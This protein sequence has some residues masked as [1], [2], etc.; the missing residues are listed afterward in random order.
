MNDREKWGRRC[1]WSEEV[2]LSEYNVKRTIVH[3]RC[4]AQKAGIPPRFILL[5]SLQTSSYFLDQTEQVST[6]MPR[7]Y[8]LKSALMASFFTTATMVQ[9]T[10]F[11]VDYSS[12]PTW[13]PLLTSVPP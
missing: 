9:S 12:D 11:F 1:F 2:S 10:I 13:P 5:L 3:P 7:K 8:I 6:E 4:V